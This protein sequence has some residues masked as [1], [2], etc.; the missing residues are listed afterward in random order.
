MD[1]LFNIFESLQLSNRKYELHVTVHV[2]NTLFRMKSN[3]NCLNNSRNCQNKS[4]MRRAIANVYF[5]LF[6]FYFATLKR[7]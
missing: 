7:Q 4:N 2:R 6:T 5:L 3:L 1:I